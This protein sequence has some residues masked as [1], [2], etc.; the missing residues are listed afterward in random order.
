MASSSGEVSG[1]S[2]IGA[3]QFYSKKAPTEKGPL[4]RARAK[5]KQ[6]EK[7]EILEKLSKQPRTRGILEALSL[8]RAGSSSRPHQYKESYL[9]EHLKGCNSMYTTDILGH[10]GCVNAL[11]FSKGEEQFLGTGM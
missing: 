7:E 11:A 9:K 3:S 6:K 8:D 10:H 2:G 5:A 4:T 1:P